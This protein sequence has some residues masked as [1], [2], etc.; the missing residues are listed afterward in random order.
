MELEAIEAIIRKRKDLS[1]YLIHWTT[2]RNFYSIL[3]FGYLKPSDA[4]RSYSNTPT[5]YGNT[6]AVCFS[7]MPIGNYLQSLSVDNRYW[8]KQ[9]MIALPKQLIYAYGGR[10]VLYGDKNEFFKRLEEEDKYLFCHFDCSKSVDWTH[11]REWRAK[12]NLEINAQISSRNDPAPSWV[13]I[14]L[15][16]QGFPVHGEYLEPRFIFVVKQEEEKE[17]LREEIIPK[18]IVDE[19]KANLSPYRIS[20]LYA[21]QKVKIFSLDYIKDSRIYDLDELLTLPQPSNLEHEIGKYWDKARVHIRRS[22]FDSI[23]DVLPGK[24]MS[25]LQPYPAEYMDW[26]DIDLDVQQAIIN[27]PTARGSLRENNPR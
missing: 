26:R 25:K 13:P 21:L 11:E 12:V 24:Y 5:I 20:Y 10:P 22:A 3:R 16:E 18:L 27:S 23:K 6:P 7:E 1:S 17:L 14:H 9:W 4:R 8:R 19:F 15:D 2:K